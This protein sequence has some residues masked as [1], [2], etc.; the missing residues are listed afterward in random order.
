M[1]TTWDVS[2]LELKESHQSPLPFFLRE[3]RAE[4]GA[5]DEFRGIFT[6]CH[7][8]IQRKGKLMHEGSNRG[9]K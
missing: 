3:R 7:T 8:T 9:I 5:E 1:P 4:S 6:C 2:A